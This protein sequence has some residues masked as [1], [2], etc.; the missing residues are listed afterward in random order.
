MKKGLLETFPS[1]FLEPLK[2]GRNPSPAF[3]LPVMV[4][5]TCQ[6]RK[7]E[8][9]SVCSSKMLLLVLRILVL[10]LT[11][12]E[13]ASRV[14][15]FI[16]ASKKRSISIHLLWQTRNINSDKPETSSPCKGRSS[17]E[18]TSYGANKNARRGFSSCNS[19]R[20]KHYSSFSVKYKSD[21]WQDS[22]SPSLILFSY[23]YSVTGVREGYRIVQNVQ[24]S[25]NLPNADVRK[26]SNFRHH[27]LFR[28]L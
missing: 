25:L 28:R 27:F 23:L 7:Q 10:F 6:N 8:A 9:N 14:P 19:K 2:L 18:N 5:R 21:T 24:K 3:S 12:G 11:V 22:T 16:S 13:V 17:W 26:S 20:C 15:L 4:L 1:S